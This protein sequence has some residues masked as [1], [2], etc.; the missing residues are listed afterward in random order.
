MFIKSHQGH[1]N[2]NGKPMDDETQDAII[3]LFQCKQYV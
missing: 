3:S 1:P 2:R